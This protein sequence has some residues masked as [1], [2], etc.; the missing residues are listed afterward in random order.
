MLRIRFDHWMAKVEQIY[1]VCQVFV[2]II[3]SPAETLEGRQSISG[4][5]YLSRK[6]SSLCVAHFF[7][8]G[9]SHEQFS[10]INLPSF[11]YPC[12]LNNHKLHQPHRI[13]RLG[14]ISTISAATGSEKSSG[15]F[16]ENCRGPRWPCAL[17]HA[18]SSLGLL[19][20]VAQ[21]PGLVG[22]PPWR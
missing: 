19:A 3:E 17:F 21:K 14:N 13:S 2:P 15:V 12:I 18:A 7:N 16:Q 20:L 5:K 8:P 11:Q 4:S 1:H 10:G 6:P 9:F 22:F